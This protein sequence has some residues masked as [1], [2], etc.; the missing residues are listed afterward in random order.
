LR[1]FTTERQGEREEMQDAAIQL[2]D[3]TKDFLLANSK[4]TKM[5]VEMI[6]QNQL[7]E[8]TYI[9][10]KSSQRA[11]HALSHYLLL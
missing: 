6:S 4:A 8:I 7:L 2:D 1:S 3:C 9:S 11:P 5:Y 10:Y